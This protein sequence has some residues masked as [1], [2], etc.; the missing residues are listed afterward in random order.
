MNKI[1]IVVPVF[2]VDQKLQICL[3]SLI[4]QTLEEIE[5]ICINDASTDRSYSILQKYGKQDARIKLIDLP[6]NRGT[7][8]ARIQGVKQASG[9]FIMFVDGDDYLETTACEKLY[10]QME[11]KNVDVIHFGTILHSEGNV[12]NEMTA[13]VEHF[14]TPFEGKIEH[15]RLVD[16]CFI[17][18][19]FDFNITNKIWKSEICKT[20]FSKV[21]IQH[22]I[23]SEDRYLFFVMMYYAKNY[24]GICDQYYHYN[25]GIGIT[26]GSTLSLK[27]FDRRCSGISAAE[28]VREFLHQEG[29]FEEYRTVQKRFADLILWDCVDCWHNKLMSQDQA[30]GF[31]ILQQY[32]LPEQ[33]MSA[34]ARVYFEQTEDIY[35]IA[36]M[37]KKK[38][39]AIYYR[40][41]GHQNM[42]QRV[43]CHVQNLKK[44]GYNVLVYTDCDR[45]DMLT[46]TQFP[47]ENIIYLPNSVSANWDKYEERAYAFAQ[48]L[49]RDE[50]CMLVY[51]SPTSHIFGL[52]MLLASMLNIPV[53]DLCDEKYL[54]EI[55]QKNKYK[56]ALFHSPRAMMQT[57]I[58]KL[59]VR[60]EQR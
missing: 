31:R 35:T 45:K 42:D 39:V 29:C 7:L 60:M 37:N 38:K 2:N 48:Q 50:V 41:L 28:L 27:Q 56:N 33:I 16:M 53:I 47:G 46:D 24:L 23:A 59:K 14:L 10:A 34:V 1:S 26:G 57:L 17:E 44:Q 25:L 18:Q 20:A 19:S 4:N 15:T 51:A 30:E 32:F 21:K 36:H 49:R 13:W 9:T 55:G 3:D 58:R 40:Y 22:L 8:N 43:A 11:Q 12:T 52:D 6:E 54:E 5:I